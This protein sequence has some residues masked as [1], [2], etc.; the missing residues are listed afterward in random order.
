MAIR[1]I[2]KL[3]DGG[4]ADVWRGQDDLEREVAVKIVRA[5]NLGVADA[6]AHAR[7][8][9]RTRHPNVVTVYR[10]DR[11]RDPDSDT[12]CD[13]VVMELIQGSTLSAVH[14]V[15]V[16]LSVPEVTRIGRAVS[17]GLAHI[18]EQGMVHGD[19][20]DENV[21]VGPDCVKLIDILYRDS[22]ALASTASREFLLRRDIT[23]LRSLVEALLENSVLG[24]ES[25]RRFNGA[26]GSRVTLERVRDAF[27][28]V[29]GEFVDGTAD[30]PEGGEIVDPTV[31]FHNERFCQ[32]FP[33]VRGARLFDTPSEIVDRLDIL[34]RKPL[35]FRGLDERVGRVVRQSPIWWWRGMSNL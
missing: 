27:E 20:H 17:D 16:P 34:L 14:S 28:S 18:H 12:E 5:A 6:L 1:L 32:A 10:L 9:A 19:L 3:G 31:Y 29:I 25:A 23:S 21:M 2:D 4:F 11:V 33:G 26:I 13:C 35:N 15:G 22:L 7:A 30:E 24:H 8:L